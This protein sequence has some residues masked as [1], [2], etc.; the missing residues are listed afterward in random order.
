MESTIDTLTSTF[1]VHNETWAL[2]I[3]MVVIGAFIIITKIISVD[4]TRN[5]RYD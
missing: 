2:L 4:T 5:K 1:Q 3:L